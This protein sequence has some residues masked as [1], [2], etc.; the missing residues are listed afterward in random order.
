MLFTGVKN[1]YCV[2]C[3]RF[4]AN[5]EPQKEHKCFKN[6]SGSSSSMEAA[7]IV[8]G[9]LVSEEMY[10]AK[11][12]KLIADGDSSVYKRILEVNPY[13][14][15]AVEKVECRNH[16][17]R[18]YCNK[19]KAI[20]LTSV[21]Q[22]NADF[23]RAMHIK[24]RKV[25][26]LNI[27]RCRAAVTKAVKYR[28][29]EDGTLHSKCM[30]LRE[31]ILNGP[32]HVFGEHKQCIRQKYFCNG[33]KEGEIN[34][35]PDL[36]KCGLYS[37]IMAGVGVLVDNVK[38]L[39]QDVDSNIAEHY[40]S[41]VARFIGGKRV[42]Y[43]LK[44]SY[45]TRCAAA[46]VS[47]NTGQAYYRL[48]KTIAKSSPSKYA[49]L[50][51]LR[52][53]RKIAKAAEKKR[54]DPKARRSLFQMTTTGNKDY[55]PRA[56]KPDLDPKTYLLKKEVFLKSLSKTADERKALEEATR[57]QGESLLWTQE[58]RMRLT[59]SNFGL[60]CNRKPYSS[61]APVITHLLYS[62]VNSPGVKYGIENEQAAIEK[63]AESLNLKIEKCGLFVDEE[64]PYL[65][66]SPD[67]LI[68]DD[69]I[70]E[71]KCPLSGSTLTPAEVINKKIGL[72]GNMFLR[73]KINGDLTVR[74]KHR[75]YYQVQ[76]QLHITKREYCIFAVW[77]PQDIIT[78]EIKKDDD[79]WRN[80]M[81][82][83]LTKF[84]MNCLLP[85]LLDS[86]RKRSMPIREPSYI[87]EAQKNRTNLTK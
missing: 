43:T 33:S 30:N 18:N 50:F 53:K 60:I 41:V 82:E 23:D 85:E 34:Y 74:K 84:Y 24:L 49:K 26:R 65:A 62:S 78:V 63:L 8:E 3:T 29:A 70:V 55:G 75:Y 27:L 15:V 14:D 48:H 58:R 56:E 46:V 39:V 57:Y 77:T 25:I 17:L 6:W 2:A 87:I 66:A 64:L 16:L 1:K 37:K 69:G 11:Y 20:T 31:D 22:P 73:N 7:T 76:G 36:V 81:E 68:G 44:G 71:V 42:N 13:D 67:G 72:V 32:S 47:H 45:Q 86:R 28:K 9:F 4:Q 19:L 21:H 5:G 61:C 59:S 12:G 83:K 40:N 51:E 38:S 10:G 79:F 35:V 54:L 52:A 80:Q